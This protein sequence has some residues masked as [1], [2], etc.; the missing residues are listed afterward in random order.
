M[1]PKTDEAFL[2]EVDEELRRDQLAGFWRRYGLYT[3][4]G[5]VLVLAVIGGVLWWQ[6]AERARAEQQG[7][8]LQQAYDALAAADA[9]KAKPLIGDLTVSGEPGNRA[10]A[11]FLQADQLLQQQDLK[12]AARLFASVAGDTSIGQPLRDL[13]LIR[14]TLAEY[15]TM[16]PQAVIDRLRPFTAGDSP[17]LGTAGEMTAVA[18]LRLNRPDQARAMFRTL[19]AAESV[20]EPIRQRAVQMATAEDPA[21][22]QKGR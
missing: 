13:A 20:P 22:E 21:N 8:K 6:S 10:S 2:R 19:A 14:Q 16:K 15:D 9:A 5:V 4:G 3:A 11:L 7:V 17:W 12:G 18:Y 1:P